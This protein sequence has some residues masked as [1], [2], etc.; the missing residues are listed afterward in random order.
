MSAADPTMDDAEC[1][2][3]RLE[4]DAPISAYAAVAAALGLPV[5]AMMIPE[6]TRDMF[7]DSARM[8]RLVK[9]MQAYL[10]CSDD[11]RRK[12][13]GMASGLAKLNRH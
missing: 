13:E 7:E 8:D 4:G 2:I 10:A 5:W 1:M 11:G 6:T 9:V 3:T 12:I